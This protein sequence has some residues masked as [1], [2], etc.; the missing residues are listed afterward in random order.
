VF[1]FSAEELIGRDAA[2]GGV[3]EFDHVEGGDLF[4]AGSAEAAHELEETAGVGGDDG[5]G[6]SGEQV[7]DFAIA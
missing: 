4:F 5:V 1:D 7:G 2:D 3:E 6:V